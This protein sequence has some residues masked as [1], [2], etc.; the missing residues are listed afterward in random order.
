M[1]IKRAIIVPAILT[2]STAGSI[3]VGSAV[4][5]LAQASGAQVVA[6]GS[7][8]PNVFLHA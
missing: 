3:L 2:I 5:L 1:R 4:P 8:S 6:V 7:P